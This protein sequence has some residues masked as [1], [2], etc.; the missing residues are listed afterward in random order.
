MGLSTVNSF[1]FAVERDF[2]AD[3][4][5]LPVEAL[6]A[7]RRLGRPQIGRVRIE[8]RDHALQGPFE[9]LAIVDSLDI[10]V[11]D[12]FQHFDEGVEH[13]AVAAAMG[14]VGL[15]VADQ[16]S[17]GHDQHRVQITPGHA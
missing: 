10:M 3:A 17:N 8:L 9:K 7:F 5:E 1:D 14:T 6:S 11:V 16:R 4:A 13:S 15:L 2:D 12:F